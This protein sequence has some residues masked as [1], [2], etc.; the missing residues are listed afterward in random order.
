M[1]YQ[2]TTKPTQLGLEELAEEYALRY[3]VTLTYGGTTSYLVDRLSDAFTAG[4]KA[5]QAQH[6]AELKREAELGFEA[7][8]VAQAYAGPTPTFEE[9]WEGSKGIKKSFEARIKEA[10]DEL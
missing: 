1:V 3:C 5:V 2:M 6:E 4:F 7:G 9:Y 10:Q 8:K